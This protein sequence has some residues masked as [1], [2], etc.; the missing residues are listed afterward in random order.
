MRLRLVMALMNTMGRVARGGSLVKPYNK[1]WVPTRQNR[2]PSRSDIMAPQGVA[3]TPFFT[4]AQNHPS[5]DELGLA[6]FRP[7]DPRPSPGGVH[8]SVTLI[9]LSGKA[10]WTTHPHVD[11][12]PVAVLSLL[13]GTL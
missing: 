1:L 12:S 3:R 7:A 4:K 11:S 2:P 13:A 5:A 6:P 10:M 9:L 8:H